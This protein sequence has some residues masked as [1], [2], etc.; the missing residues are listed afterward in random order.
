MS[1]FDKEN[2]IMISEIKKLF[3]DLEN[4]KVKSLDRVKHT[5]RNILLKA[6]FQ[7]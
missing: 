1:L 2:E 4:N 7:S 3:L 6:G 5:L